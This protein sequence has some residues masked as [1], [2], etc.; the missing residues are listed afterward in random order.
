MPCFTK[1]R[2]REIPNISTVIKN[3]EIKEWVKNPSL[4]GSKWHELNI[5]FFSWNF[6]CEIISKTTEKH[7]EIRLRFVKDSGI[8]ISVRDVSDYID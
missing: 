8:T 7:R 2:K 5:A 1:N 6:A 3:V 4:T